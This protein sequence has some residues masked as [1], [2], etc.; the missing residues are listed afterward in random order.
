[1]AAIPLPPF[2]SAVRLS[3]VHQHLNQEMVTG[4][5]MQAPAPV[6]FDEVKALTIA[7]R[8][9]WS[10][11]MQA[12]RS[13]RCTFVAVEG[14]QLVPGSGLGYDAPVATI[15]GGDIT[16]DADDPAR[17]TVIKLKTERTGKSYR[18]RAYLP[19]MPNNVVQDGLVDPG[20]RLFC[21]ERLKAVLDGLDALPGGWTPVVVS[22]FHNNA[23]RPAPVSTRIED[24]VSVTRRPGHMS[25]RAIKQ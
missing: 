11:L 3:F 21:A 10:T 1:M 20:Y 24:A 4:L 13:F 14:R 8:G 7:A 25:S 9:I 5:T 16:E 19:G 17:A 2:P 23:M 6:G 12:T 18:G 22:F 15:V